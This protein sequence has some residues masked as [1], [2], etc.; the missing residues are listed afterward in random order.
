VSR[1]RRWRESY[2]RC[3]TR[4]R[5]GWWLL[6]FAVLNWPAAAVVCAWRSQWRIEPFEQLMVFYSLAALAFSAVTAIL[7]AEN[8]DTTE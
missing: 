8:G 2:R 7:A 1:I 6:A 5:L 4:V 3:G